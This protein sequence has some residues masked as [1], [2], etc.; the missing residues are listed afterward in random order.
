MH[1]QISYLRPPFIYEF[2]IPLPASIS[3][4][5][6]VPKN[7]WCWTSCPTASNPKPSSWLLKEHTHSREVESEIL[8]VWHVVSLCKI[9]QNF[10][11]S[12][13]DYYGQILLL[14]SS[15]L[16]I[17]NVHKTITA[18]HAGISLENTTNRAY[19]SSWAVL[20]SLRLRTTCDL[21]LQYRDDLRLAHMMEE[22]FYYI[23]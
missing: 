15:H 4:F 8:C 1:F 18:V 3:V 5:L 20:K 11:P 14:S 22:W 17:E 19:S 16:A 21:M 13:E 6:W 9:G 12:C 2:K 23:L 7:S 10:L